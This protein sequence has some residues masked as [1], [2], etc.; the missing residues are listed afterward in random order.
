MELADK[1]IR[2]NAVTPAV[3]VTPIYGAFI[4]PEKIEDALTNGFDA[5][6]PVGRVGRRE[7]VA[8]YIAF[9]LSDRGRLDDWV[10]P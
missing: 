1:N 9:L 6:H 3:V 8:A 2:L 4:P 10:H 7:D 5:F